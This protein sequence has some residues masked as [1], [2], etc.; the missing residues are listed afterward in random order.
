MVVIPHIAL[1]NDQAGQVF[2][3]IFAVSRVDSLLDLLPRHPLNGGRNLG[4][5]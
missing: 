1:T 5:Q 2:E 3:R 4:W